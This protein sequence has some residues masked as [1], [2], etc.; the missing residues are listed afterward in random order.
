M[1]QHTKGLSIKEAVKR[2]KLKPNE[3][4]AVMDDKTCKTYKWLVNR[5]AKAKAKK[6]NEKNNQT[7]S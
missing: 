1:A 7:S 4:M 3:A 6:T 5:V 2:G